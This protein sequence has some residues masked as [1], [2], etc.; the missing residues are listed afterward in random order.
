MQRLLMCLA[1]TLWALFCASA[2]QAPER[3]DRGLVAMVAGDGRVYL[4]WRLLMTDAEDAGFNV[5]RSTAG[6]G[7]RALRLN[8][9]PLTD[10]TNFVDSNPPLDR[11]NAWWVRPVRN[12]REQEASGRAELPANPPRRQ[13][14]PIRLKG[15]YTPNKIGIGDL[16]GDRSEE[17][18]VGKECRL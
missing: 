1:G 5:Y 12:G 15:D 13:Y 2:A 6:A 4:G 9:Q 14:V 17:R 7:G 16:D 8:K 11:E 3:M 10:S 18:R